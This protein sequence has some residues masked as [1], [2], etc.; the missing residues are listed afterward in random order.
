[1]TDDTTRHN[2]KMKRIKAARD[3]MMAEKTANKGLIIVHTGKGKGKSSSAFGMALRCIGHGYKIGVVQFIKG[4]WETGEAKVLNQ[5]PDH[6][7]FKAMGAGFTWETQ[8]KEQDIALA[9]K[10]WEM[11]LEMLARPDYKMVILDELNIVLRY[12]FLPLEEVIEALNSKLPDQHVVITGRNAAAE[13]IEKADLVTEMT[14]IK[15]P[16][17]EQ[18]IKAQPGVEY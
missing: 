3:K 10:A 17:R 5:F 4:G 6:C 14:L 11:A 1:M 2:Q 16:F 7:V 8:N 13:L 18:G 9:R 12:G 15:H